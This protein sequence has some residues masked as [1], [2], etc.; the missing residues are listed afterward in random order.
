[1]P[2]LDG[3]AL[4]A[5]G[6]DGA[7]IEARR[8]LD[9]TRALT[10]LAELPAL[11]GRWQAELGLEDARIM[12]GGLLSAAFACRRRDDGSRAVL[13]LSAA[14][15]TSAPAEAAALAAWDGTGACRLIFATTDGRAM[16]LDAIVPGTPVKPGEERADAER[17]GA[18][19]VALQRLPATRVPPAIPDAGV[20]LAWRFDRAHRML[21]GPSPGKGLVSHEEIES[22]REAALA[23]HAGAPTRVMCHGDFLDKNILVGA[24][25]EWVAIDPRP[26]IADPCLDAAFWCLAHRPGEQVRQR[27]RLISEAAGLNADR[28]WAWAR[29]FA[30]SEAV[31]VRDARRSQAHHRVALSDR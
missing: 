31:L 17:A 26:C 11:A 25:D 7:L 27:C 28:T 14:E 22:A 20:E 16:L 10:F 30:V 6:V 8:R 1:V 21:D 5:L 19:L 24:G 18:L 29:T 13:K 3:R 23:L 4:A 12:P 9:G 2:E 15:A